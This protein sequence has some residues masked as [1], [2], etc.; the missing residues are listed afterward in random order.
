MTP[1]T[2]IKIFES[3]ARLETR[4]ESIE[5]G[6]LEFKVS[7]KSEIDD[8]GKKYHDLANTMQ[9]YFLEDNSAP[10]SV[11]DKDITAHGKAIDVM[12]LRL[13]AIERKANFIAG[14]W[15]VLTIVCSALF[16]WLL[17]VMQ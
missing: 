6:L 14:G 4:F 13:D 2:E 17:K 16:S 8:R 12:L 1:D 3:I 11:H 10:C 15:A 9:K 7:I 5:K